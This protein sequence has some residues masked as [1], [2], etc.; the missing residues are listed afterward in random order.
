MTPNPTGPDLFAHS[1]KS[2]EEAFETQGDTGLDNSGAQM[3]SL[4]AAQV[5]ATQAQTAAL[6]MFA[7]L[8]ADA[9]GIRSREVEVWADAIPSPP[10]VECWGKETRRPECAERHTD[11]CEYTDPIPEPKHV[12]L[13]VGTRVL[14]SDPHGTN[15]GCSNAQPWVGIVKGYD[16]HRS[17]YQ[18]NE[19][20]HYDPGT[21]YNHVRWVFADNRVQP[22]PEQPTPEPD[23][24]LTEL[25]SR[26]ERVWNCEVRR[27]GYHNG[28]PCTPDDP[29]A[30]WNCGYV[31]KFPLLTDKGAREIG[32]ITDSTKEN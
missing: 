15:C 19:E 26:F 21:Y 13:P 18:I 8:Y 14:V 31:W 27:S 28:D 4:L 22:H 5:T 9:H 12:L 11:D 24:A 30:G 20:R 2:Y 29:H 25:L 32:L 6:V 17:K 23:T 1:W 16:M 3:L 7:G 10:L